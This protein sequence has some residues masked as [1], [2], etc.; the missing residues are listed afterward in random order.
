MSNIR[1]FGLPL[2]E[3]KIF[4]NLPNFTPFCPLLGPNRCQPLDFR[5][6]ESPFPKDTS[7]QKFGSNQFSGFG[8]EVV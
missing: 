7:Y 4:L 1:V 2:H 6:V 5:K 3:K 8:E